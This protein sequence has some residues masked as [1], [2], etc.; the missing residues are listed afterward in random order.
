MRISET[1]EGCYND[2]RSKLLGVE[3][4]CKIIVDGFLILELDKDR[5]PCRSCL[6][7]MT[8]VKPCKKYNNIDLR[9]RV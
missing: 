9:K 1:C 3:R 5:C 8:C 2:N 6:V 4:F 7:K